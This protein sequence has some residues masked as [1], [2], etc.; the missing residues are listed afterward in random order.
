MSIILGISSC[1]TAPAI[2]SVNIGAAAEQEL[3]D[4]DVAFAGGDVEGGAAVQIDAVDVDAVV[5]QVLEAFGVAS[6]GHEEKMHRGVEVLRHRELGIVG[7]TPADWIER[8]LPAEA[9]A[10]VG[11]PRVQRRLPRELAAERPPERP[12]RELPRY[13]TL[14]LR[15]YVVH[16]YRDGKTI[17][18]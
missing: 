6:A 16:L 11:L 12:R 18:K 9:E 5:E 15:R 4:V 3:G 8:G 13:S 2:A 17:R 7:G 10:E 14:Q 1:R